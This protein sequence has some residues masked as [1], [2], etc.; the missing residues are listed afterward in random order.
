MK[1]IYKAFATALGAGYSPFAPGTA[2]AIVGCIALWLFEKYNIISTTSTPILF[3]GLITGTTVLG[4][5]ATNNLE[6]EWGKDPQKVVIDEVI[7]LWITMMFI[8][9]TWL[10][11]LIAFVLFRFFDIAKPLG[12]RKME[13][14]GGGLGVMADDMLAGIY[15]NIVLLIIIRFL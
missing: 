1:I 6:K 2:G 3:I 12:I 9:F 7:G 13:S 11:L 5:I 15:G 4:I 8:P 10:N 14:L